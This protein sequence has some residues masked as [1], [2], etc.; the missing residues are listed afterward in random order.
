VSRVLEE[1][2]RVS[3]VEYTEGAGE[4]H[5][6]RARFV[7]DASGNRSRINGAMGGERVYAEFFRDVALF[8]YFERAAHGCR[9][10]SAAAGRS[11]RGR[12][13]L[14]DAPPPR[15]TDAR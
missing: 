15:P 14:T 2:D 11:G 4:R 1:D 5:T 13:G 3:G 9:N 6:A 7:I 10:H 8:G 12:R